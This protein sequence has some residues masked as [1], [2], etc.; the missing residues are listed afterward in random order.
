MQGFNVIAVYNTAGTSILMCKRRKNPYIGLLNLVGG[1]IEK[2]EN[3]LDAA[4]REL[5]EETAVSRRDITLAHL[6]DYTYYFYDLYLEV[7][8]GVLNKHVDVCGT[9]N[10]LVWVDL[11]EDFFDD[12]KFAGQGNIGHILKQIEQVKGRYEDT[13]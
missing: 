9:E 4:Y 7:Y 13:L 1:K 2:D 12:T 6:M 10:D 11:D 5:E 3:G 8:F